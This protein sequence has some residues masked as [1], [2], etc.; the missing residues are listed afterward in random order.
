VQQAQLAL[1]RLPADADFTST[2]ARN[3]DE[4]RLLLAD[5]SKW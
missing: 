4:W 5:M 1:E 3:R 2:T